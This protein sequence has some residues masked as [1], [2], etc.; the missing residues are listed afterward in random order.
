MI[1]VAVDAMGGDNAP[2][3]IVAGA[4]DA[5]NDQSDI[6]ILL[7]GREDAIEEE[8]KKGSYPDGS[9]R[10]IPASEVIET[11]EPPVNAIRQKKDSSMVVGMQLVKNGE[12]DAFVSAGN[13]GALLAGGQLIVG[14]IRG[15]E[16]A[17]FGALIPTQSGNSLLL[18]AGASVDPRPSMLVQFAQMGY[19]YMRDVCGV[20]NPTVGIVNIGE[21]EEKGNALVKET[22][23]LLKE[24]PDINFIGSVE[25]RA[26]PAGG[27][28]VIVT[29]AFT[30]NVILKM[31]E[32]TMSTLFH[33]FED[34][35]YS[36]L[37]SKMGALLILPALKN[38][39]KSLNLDSQGGAPM[40]G[41][42]GLVVKAHG[43]SKRAEIHNAIIQ[44]RTFKDRQINEK[45]SEALNLSDKS[46]KEEQ[47]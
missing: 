13:S 42:K 19:I 11:S 10:V 34:T 40:L 18:D 24:C 16:R 46:N 4:I 12:A 39:I 1:T 30:G 14:R 28:D 31:Y 43:N 33:M 41:L 3:E 44:C 35:L 47:S 8:L 38:M 32:G 6:Q 25:A 29:D 22:F 17:P 5:V 21:E 23:P 45:I 26:I 27:T 37:R 2:E 36:S 20:E 15:V 7:T 9:I